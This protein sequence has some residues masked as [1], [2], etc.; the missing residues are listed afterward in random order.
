MLREIEQDLTADMR[1]MAPEIQNAET[2]KKYLADICEYLY[3]RRE[4]MRILLNC[5]TDEDMVVMFSEMN[6]RY[7]SQYGSGNDRGLDEAG[8]MLMVT[9]FSSGGYYLIRQWLMEDVQKTPQEVADLVFH[10]VTRM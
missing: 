8:S 4:I 6:R 3:A 1:K 7:W 9:F 5:R 2:G 10:L